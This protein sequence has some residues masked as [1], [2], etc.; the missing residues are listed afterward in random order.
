MSLF[1]LAFFGVALGATIVVG[2]E[3]INWKLLLP[4]L[5]FSVIVTIILIFYIRDWIK[6]IKRYKRIYSAGFTCEAKA[7]EV[8]VR[9]EL[10]HDSD[11]DYQ[12]KRYYGIRYALSAGDEKMKRETGSYPYSKK[13]AEKIVNDYGK[14]TVIYSKELDDALYIKWKY[15]VDGVPKRE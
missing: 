15:A 10:E 1:V 5:I 6:T 3:N 11:K 13:A 8:C 12:I 2:P 9:C 4:F 7:L 14:F